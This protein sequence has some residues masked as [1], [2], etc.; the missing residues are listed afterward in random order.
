MRGAAQAAEGITAPLSLPR[1]VLVRYVPWLRLGRD[2]AFL[3]GALLLLVWLAWGVPVR[4]TPVVRVTLAFAGLNRG[5]MPPDTQL[6]DLTAQMV[7]LDERGHDLEGEAP[8]PGAAL[9]D[10]FEFT[11]PTRWYGFRWLGGRG[12]N[13]WSRRPQRFRVT[14]TPASAEAS[15]FK[16]YDLNAV[17]PDGSPAYSAEG[18]ASPFKPLVA[19]ATFTAPAVHGVLVNLS[20]GHLG[21]LA[22]KDLR[23]VTV[24]Y[25]LDGQEQTPRTVELIHDTEGGLRPITLDLTDA[26][27]LG[28]SRTFAVKVTA[29][30]LSSYDVQEIEVQ[31]R[32]KPLPITL[33]FPD[34]YPKKAPRLPGVPSFLP[35]SRPGGSSLPPRNPLGFSALPPRNPVGGPSLPPR[36]LFGGPSLP[37]HNPLGGSSLPHS[38]P[39]GSTL[40]TP[41]LGGPTPPPTHAMPPEPPDGLVAQP[42][43]PTQINIRWNRVPDAT[44]Y[45]LYRSGGPESGGGERRLDGDQT[46]FSDTGLTPGVVYRYRIQSK[47]G[48]LMSPL[49]VPTSVAT[50]PVMAATATVTLTVSAVGKDV[51]AVLEFANVSAQPFYLDKVSAC[52][53]GKI[54]DDVFRILADGQPVPF[55]GQKSKRRSDPGGAPVH[56]DAPRRQRPHRSRLKPLVPTPAGDA[57]LRCDL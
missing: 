1:P 4:K 3:L 23:N 20:L 19:S 17:Q 30:G 47:R 32:D 22:G 34:V 57:R 12:W 8:I 35:H 7:L 28:G 6:K 46:S 39:G 37:L 15:A 41:D 44:K 27:P 36:N 25:T 5:Q 51:H 55:T 53:G 29:E 2:W 21:A 52:S 48:T 49:S 38:R 18:L 40:P 45:V 26:V 42:A 56:H 54:G 11:A 33:A 10:A 50:P 16:R 43:G 14:V 31:R 13:G 9:G 24:R